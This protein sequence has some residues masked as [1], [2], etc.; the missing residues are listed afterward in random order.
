MRELIV[1]AAHGPDFRQHCATSLAGVDHIVL[2]TDEIRPNSHPTAVYRWAYENTDADRFLFVQDCMVA[3]T[4]DPCA[5][6]RE[7]LPPD[8]GA[9]AWGRFHLA[10]DAPEQR[11]W[12]EDQYPGQTVDYGIMGPIFYT[13]RAS[14]DVLAQRELLPEIPNGRLQAQGTERAWA[15]AYAAAGLPVVGPLW[16][17]H[18]MQHGFNGWRKTWAGRP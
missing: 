7:Q 11:Q 12:V 2:D 8:G 16:N 15:Y 4:P 6:F 14:L 5:W 3:L 18:Q 1:V 13:T 10:W 17:M 9:V